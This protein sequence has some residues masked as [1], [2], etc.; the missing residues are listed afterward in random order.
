MPELSVQEIEKHLQD[1]QPEIPWTHYYQFGHD[2]ESVS[3]SDGKF[4]RKALGLGRLPALIERIAGQHSRARRIQGGR[5]LDIASAEGAH[6]VALA[7]LGADVTGIE[8][9]ELYVRRARF[10]ARALGVSTVRFE[11][12]DVRDISTTEFGT[13]DI[14]LCFGILHHLDMG[15]FMPF[16][17]NLH[18]LT[19]DLLVMYTHTSTPAAIER[20]RLSGPV[21][22]EGHEGWLFREHQDHASREERFDQVRASLDNTMSFWATPESLFNAL[23][24]VGFEDL[25]SLHKPHLFRRFAD[26]DFRPIIVARR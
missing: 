23:S 12:M 4:Y 9:R 2:I 16:L 26:Q 22:I 6:S 14:V 21:E 20:F 1:L 8:G 15:S 13:F 24:E 7:Q 18:A 11:Q 10:A 25:Y 19:G 5:V 17:R 3:E